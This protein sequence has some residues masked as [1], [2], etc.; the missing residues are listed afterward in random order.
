V[1]ALSVWPGR[2]VALLVVAA[3]AGCDGP[4]SRTE[5]RRRVETIG[6]QAAEGALVAEGAARNRTKATFTRVQAGELASRV[7][8]EA[9]KLSDGE[10]LGEV[11]DVRP[12]ALAL[13]E[14]VVDT[15]GELQVS[16]IDEDL[17]RRVQRR[18]ARLH[19]EAFLLAARR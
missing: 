6:A 9:E 1:T 15:L 4:M 19:S 12:E 17:A 10:A 7:T 2:I 13:A 14:D 8:H 11:A 18:L 16:P 5:L 3:L